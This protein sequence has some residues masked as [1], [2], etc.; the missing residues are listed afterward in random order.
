VL[1]ESDNIKEYMHGHPKEFIKFPAMVDNIKGSARIARNC[2]RS[3]IA[4]T[5]THP[6]LH[7]SDRP[8]PRYLFGEEGERKE[9]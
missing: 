7:S 5:K 3:V 8:V 2:S 1:S 9:L 4:V 6:L